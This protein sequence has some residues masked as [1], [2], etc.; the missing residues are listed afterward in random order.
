[1]ESPCAVSTRNK[2]LWIS[3][4][5]Y[6]DIVVV[7]SVVLFG[8]HEHVPQIERKPVNSQENLITC[9]KDPV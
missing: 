8:K 3:L 9:E 6:S 5:Y 1:M 4:L 7:G 2:F